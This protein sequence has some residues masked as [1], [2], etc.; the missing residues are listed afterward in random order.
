MNKGAIVSIGLSLALMSCSRDVD[1]IPDPP[2][3]DP[4]TI[5]SS[6]A[7]VETLSPNANYRPAFTGQTRI[8]GV[9]TTTA[10]RTSIVTS[11]L[12][13]PWGI[14]S[15]PDGRLLVTQKGGNMRIVTATGT[16]S[17]AITGIPAVNASGQGGLLG[18]CI[19]P[20]FA[21]NRMI[22]WAFSEN[23]AGGTVTSVAKGR[24]SDNETTVDA[25]RTHEKALRI[26]F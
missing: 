20:A 22:Y 8:N 14:T 26:K 6:G 16:V 21:S 12:S 9:R 7:P 4:P 11:A 19:D 23:V 24:L 13:A 15:L 18:L 2:T 5:D 10:I 3:P 25:G 17:S 1:T